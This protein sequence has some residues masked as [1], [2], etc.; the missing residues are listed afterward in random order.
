[1]NYED[2]IIQISLDG[3]R[4]CAL[5]GE[6]VQVGVCGFGDTPLEALRELCDDFER[7]AYNMEGYTIG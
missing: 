2:L 1:M 5:V 7:Q 3:D 6:N 4:W